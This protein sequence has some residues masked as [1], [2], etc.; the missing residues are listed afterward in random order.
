[1]ARALGGD[2]DDV[3]TGLGGDVAEADVEAVAEDQRG[4]VLEV[5]G[6]LVA[7]QVTLHLI[8][9]QD[10]DHVGAL[11][12]LGDGGDRE[13]LVLRLRPRG[14]A[15]AQADGHLDAGVAQVQRVRVPLAAV[16]DDGDLLPLDDRQV[17]VVVVEQLSHDGSPWCVSVGAT[18]GGVRRYG[19]RARG[20]G[21]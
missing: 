3:V 1:V 16:P 13:A 5:R 7:V 10:H 21:R 20:R 14:G 15:L 8:R 18:C 4:A 6:D 11:D 2:H 17:G 19:R 12:G 9:R